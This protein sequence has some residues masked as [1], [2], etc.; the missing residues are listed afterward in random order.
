MKL[1]LTATNHFCPMALTEI[2]SGGR[3]PAAN[4]SMNIDA[5]RN[6]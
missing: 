1:P 2:K 4:E 5:P 6:P 3:P